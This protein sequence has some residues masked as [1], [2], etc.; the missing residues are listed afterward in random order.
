MSIHAA[1]NGII[2]FFFMAEEYSIVYTYLTFFIHS[3]VS[4][5]TACL[6]VLAVVCGATVNIGLHVSFW[7]TVLFGYVPRR[8]IVGSYGHYF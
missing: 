3:S 8:E 1:A 2:L 5:C 6:Y 4:G 7:I